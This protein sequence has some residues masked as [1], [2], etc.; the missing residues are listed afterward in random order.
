MVLYVL[1]WSKREQC[2]LFSS[3]P[4]FSHFLCYPI[5]NWAQVGGL[6]NYRTLW[7]SPANSPVRLGVSPAATTPTG[8]H[9][10]RFWGFLFQCWNPGFR[11]P[12]RSPAVPPGLSTSKCG[13]TQ[14]IPCHVSS[15]PWLPIS[16]LLPV[17]MNVSLNPWLSDFHISIFWQF[18][19]FFVFKFVVVILLVVQGGK[20]YLPMPPLG[21]KTK[22]INA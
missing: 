16:A 6:V 2:C 19:L 21:Q 10:H 11:G 22:L 17:W 9:S 7:V 15:P 3:L 12:P 18:W 20:V 4:A 1:E 14:S 13:I 8:L 5:A